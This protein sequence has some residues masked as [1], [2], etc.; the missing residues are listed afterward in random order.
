MYDFSNMNLFS[1]FA[2][3]FLFYVLLVALLAL[4]GYALWKAARDNQRNWFI[5]LL[6][7]HGTVVLETAYLFFFAK[8]KLTL[9]DLKFWER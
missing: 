6:V 5:A 1:G 3:Q 8:H 9:D 7:I 2:G 4:N